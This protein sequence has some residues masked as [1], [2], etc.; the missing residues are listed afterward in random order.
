MAG[1]PMFSPVVSIFVVVFLT[2]PFGA[3]ANTV[4]TFWESS[5]FISRDQKPTCES[6][7]LV[8]IEDTYNFQACYEAEI[9]NTEEGS[10]DGIV[11]IRCTPYFMKYEQAISPCLADNDDL[12]QTYTEE[13]NDWLD[14]CP[15][16]IAGRNEKPDCGYVIVFVAVFGVLVEDVVPYYL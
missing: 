7:D 10:E 9:L 6:G 14:I 5:E 3:E 12:K 1:L 2:W 8:R 11:C 16:Y 13:Y 15:C 4:F